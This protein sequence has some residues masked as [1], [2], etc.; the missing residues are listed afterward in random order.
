MTNIWRTLTIDISH[1]VNSRVVDTLSHIDTCFKSMG[2]NYFLGGAQARDLIL[3]HV[4]GIPTTRATSDV[5]IGVCV[6]DWETFKTLKRQLI[7]TC[8]FKEEPKKIHRLLS[9]STDLPIDLLPFGGV[10]DISGSIVWPPDME[11][12]MNVAGF[13]EAE[14]SCVKVQINNNLIVPVASLPALVVLKLFAWSD[15]HFNIDNQKKDAIDVWMILNAYHKAGNEERL[16]AEESALSSNS[17][18]DLKFA[19]V[20]LLGKDAAGICDL[21]TAVKLIQAFGSENLKIFKDDILRYR[22]FTCNNGDSLFVD[23]YI[24]AFWVHFKNK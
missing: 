13:S 1:P 16:Y 8:H 19:A 14:R 10:E 6:E 20:K 12:T 7:D 22:P 21:E 18:W 4:F 17:E 15:R 3:F 11:Q 24:D 9:T 23:K 5:D 2:K